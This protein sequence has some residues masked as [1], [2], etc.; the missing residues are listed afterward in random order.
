MS[1]SLDNQVTVVIRSVGERTE[2]VSKSLILEQGIPE[3][4]IHVVRETPFSKAMRASFTIGANVQLRWTLCVDADLLLRPGAVKAMMELA[5]REDPS[6]CGIQGYCLDKFFG[7]PR[8]GGVHLYRTSMLPTVLKCIPEEGVNIRPEWRTLQAMEDR[9]YPWHVVQYL[10]GLHDFEQFYRDIFRKCF[11]HAHKHLQYAEFFVSI[12]REQA[13]TA[14]DFA[15]ALSAFARGIE[16]RGQV[17]ID[18]RQRIYEAGLSSLN[19]QEKDP[20]PSDQ[21]TLADIETVIR[22]WREPEAYH[23]FFPNKAGLISNGDCEQNGSK[24]ERGRRRLHELGPVR[25]FP[26]TLGW[27]LKNA[28]LRLQ[29]A[30]SRSE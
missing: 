26:Y 5:E 12:W 21:L 2:Q 9:G 24:S 30:A 14:T 22:E 4:R 17:L 16:H 7:G 27:A 18:T 10:I 1:S 6:V 8:L 3:E 25:I 29:N 23:R 20:I 19:I 13:D 15:V 11:V 28:G